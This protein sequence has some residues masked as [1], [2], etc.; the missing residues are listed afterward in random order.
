MSLI[1]D[2]GKYY[3]YINKV[4]TAF[5][6]SGYYE[7]ENK[8]DYR[9]IHN[10]EGINFL[11]EDIEYSFESADLIGESEGIELYLV[12]NNGEK[13]YTLFDTE[14]KMSREEAEEAFDYYF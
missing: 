2:I 5:G 7:L 13:Y 10:G 3:T 6:T 11:M 14:N 1:E 8:I 9:Y 4:F 12:Q